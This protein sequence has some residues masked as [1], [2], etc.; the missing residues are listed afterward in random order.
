VVKMVEC[1]H[2]CCRECAVNFFSVVIKDQNINQAVCPFCQAPGDLGEDDDVALKYFADLDILL[3]DLLEKEVHDLFQR[4]L[5]DRTLM[6]DPNFK[7][8][9]KCPFGFLADPKNK[10][11][12]CPDCRAMSCAKCLLP[13][14]AQHEGNSCADFARW[15]AENDPDR[16]AAGL[17]EHMAQ[18]GIS[19]PACNFRYTLTK[20]GCMHF[21]CSQCKFEFCIGC[22]RP[23]KL[24]TRCGKGPGCAKMGLHA[25]HPRN[26]LFYLRDK[27]P[28]DLKKLLKKNKVE[29]D[30]TG[31]EAECRV[32]VQKDTGDGVVD[33]NCG[34][35]AAKGQA[36]YCRIHYVEYL[37]DLIIDNK[38]E[39]VS[40]MELGEV[41][42]VFTRAGKFIPK[43]RPG[44]YEFQFTRRLIQVVEQEI[45]LD[46]V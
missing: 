1:E 7:W 32:Q 33:G 45:P 10:K 27:E 11:L 31:E 4:K 21:T 6:K 13:W 42:A 2:I 40:L 35:M 22:K 16:Q 46:S 44:E 37:C 38:L 14:E 17:E 9:Y 8:C 29:Y 39:V 43:Q 3:K 12:V 19:C 36:G 18:H 34:E 28:A 24:V 26:C 15:K 5:R 41:K 25:H 23:F 30:T 20:G